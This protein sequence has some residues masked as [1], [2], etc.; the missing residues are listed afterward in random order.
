MSDSDR[1]STSMFDFLCNMSVCLSMSF[2]SCFTF[3]FPFV[4]IQRFYQISFY[5]VDLY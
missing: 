5:M 3:L 1:R 2:G 4:L